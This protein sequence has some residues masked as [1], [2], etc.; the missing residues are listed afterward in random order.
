M[1][2]ARRRDGRAAAAAVATV[3]DY[4]RAHIPRCAN[5]GEGEE[6]RVIALLPRDLPGLAAAARP[7]VVTD[8]AD[9]RGARLAPHRKTRLADTRG[10][11]GAAL[12]VDDRVHSVEHQGN[13][14][15]V[16]AEE[17]E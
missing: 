2:A 11:G 16:E 10:I 15:R 8:M 14:L 12:L 1:G 6:Q 5:R 13:G 9:L 3:L 7:L 4:R 17:G